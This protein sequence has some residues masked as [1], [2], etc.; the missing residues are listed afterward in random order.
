MEVVNAG[1]VGPGWPADEKRMTGRGIGRATQSP[2][3]NGFVSSATAA[4]RCRVGG[5][6]GAVR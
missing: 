5:S 6:L 2:A 4:D 3:P 1:R